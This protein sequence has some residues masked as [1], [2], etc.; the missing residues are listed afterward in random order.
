MGKLR[1]HKLCQNE[2]FST[3]GTISPNSKRKSFSL[4][5]TIILF[6][7]L[8]G[9]LKYVLVFPYFGF[10]PVSLVILLSSLLPR[11]G[12]S[13]IEVEEKRADGQENRC[14]RKPED[15]DPGYSS[16]FFAGDLQGSLFNVVLCSNQQIISMVFFVCNSEAGVQ[17]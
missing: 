8:H 11:E 7:H 14:S 17:A 3:A 16:S 4:S 9:L 5:P 1:L 12:H 15:S 2:Q 6:N 10:S 13:N